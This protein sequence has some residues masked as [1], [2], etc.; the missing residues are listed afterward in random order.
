MEQTLFDFAQPAPPV[1]QKPKK[2]ATTIT[3]GLIG[4]IALSTGGFFWMQQRAEENRLAAIRGQLK[5][6]VLADNALALEVL[7]MDESA[8]I[9]YAEFFKR[10]DKN[11]ENRDD[12][13]RQVR[14][15]EAGPYQATA[16]NFV[17][18]MELESEFVRAEEDLSRQTMEV[19]SRKDSLESAVTS[20]E[21]A[22]NEYSTARAKYMAAPY[23]EDYGE[24]VSA[25]LAKARVDA[26]QTEAT[27]VVKKY[28]KAQEELRTKLG[29]AE[30]AVNDWIRVEHTWYPYAFAPSRDV[31]SFLT[32][33]KTKYHIA[34]N[35]APGSDKPLS[36][37]P[38]VV[39]VSAP[40]AAS[41]SPTA[42][43]KVEVPK[44]LRST[45]AFPGERFPETRL[46]ELTTDEVSNYEDDGLRYAINEMYARYGMEFR[47]KNYQANFTQWSWYHPD[48][49]WTPNQIEGQ[50]TADERSNM[51]L[52]IA[53]RDA[54]QS[55][56]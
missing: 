23:G 36:S 56:E 26:A 45:S 27:E 54:R 11:K 5:A 52:L 13:V 22:S 42:T 8:H 24:K 40:M 38:T 50:F 2:R 53:E 51:K 37:A 14:A 3:L 9:T 28:A 18:L 29:A 19:S 34:A 35:D 49:R 7:E 41:P 55:I 17:K 46:R 32:K 12:L 6:L 47:D 33:R 10:T 43:P 44:R 25:D 31:I 30:L 39:D 21:D 15:I 4:V 20:R 1:K 48:K 16:N